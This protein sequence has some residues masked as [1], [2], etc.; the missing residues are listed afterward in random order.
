MFYHQLVSG[1]QLR[2]L[3]K[4]TKSDGSYHLPIAHIFTDCIL[5]LIPFKIDPVVEVSAPEHIVMRQNSSP[6][7]MAIIDILCA[8]QTIHYEKQSS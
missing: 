1:K 2:E 3:L 5:N 6:L 4:S 7:Q 8:I